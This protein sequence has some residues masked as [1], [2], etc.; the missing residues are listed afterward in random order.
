MRQGSRSA[1]F[2]LAHFM[3]Q[4]RLDAPFARRDI[5][6]NVGLRTEAVLSSPAQMP[7]FRLPHSK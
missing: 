1:P 2:A 6:Q 5:M 3:K 7:Q 4:M